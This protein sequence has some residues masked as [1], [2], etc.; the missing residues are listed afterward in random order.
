MRVHFNN[1]WKKNGEIYSRV[2]WCSVRT[3]NILGANHL[4]FEWV[5]GGRGEVWVISEKNILLNL[6]VKF[7]SIVKDFIGKKN[8]EWFKEIAL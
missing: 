3:R 1:G 2:N 8:L 7:C 6:Q 5:G 4:T